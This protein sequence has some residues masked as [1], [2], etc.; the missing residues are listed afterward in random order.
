[1]AV[2]GQ[3]GPGDHPR[4]DHLERPLDVLPHCGLFRLDLALRMEEGQGLLQKRRVVRGE[5][6]LGQREQRPEYDVAMGI[7][8]PNGA[9]ALEKHE[10]L[11]PV[12]VGVLVAK[13]PHQDVADRLRAAEG[14]QQF[15]RALGHVAGTPAAAGILFQTTRG[16]VVDERV[17]DEPGQDLR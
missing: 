12:A 2:G 1:M 11:R 4:A 3:P 9:L 6:V 5:E 10:P 14:E 15:H 8:G 7:A 17:M 13:D 16:E